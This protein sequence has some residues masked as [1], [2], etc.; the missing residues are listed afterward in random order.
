VETKFTPS[1]FKKYHQLHLLGEHETIKF[2]LS[3]KH[4]VK[5]IHKLPCCH[6]DH[7]SIFR[8][9]E[10]FFAWYSRIENICSVRQQPFEISRVRHKLIEIEE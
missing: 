3:V 6:I 8:M 7:S 5:L 1:I 2:Q 9:R 10:M 4:F